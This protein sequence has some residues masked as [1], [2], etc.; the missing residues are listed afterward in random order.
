META[1]NDCKVN[2]S[3][4]CSFQLTFY[5]HDNSIGYK[6]ETIGRSSFHREWTSVMV[7]KHP[8]LI[9]SK[10]SCKSAIIQFREWRARVESTQTS[11]RS[12]DIPQEY[13]DLVA[14]LAHESDESLNSLANRLNDLLSP[15]E[16]NH[17]ATFSFFKTIKQIIKMSAY[18]ERYG[19]ADV[20]L[21]MNG[22]PSTMPKRLSIFRW[23]AYDTTQFPPDVV[24]AATKKREKRKLF[25]TIFTNAFQS[26]S[27]R[28]RIDLLYDQ[29]GSFIIES[30]L[31]E[32]MNTKTALFSSFKQQ[33]Y[34]SLAPIM[35]Q[36]RKRLCPSFD[37]L[38]YVGLN[39][40][41]DLR[42]RFLKELPLETKL[43]RGILMQEVDLKKA[44]IDSIK[45]GAVTLKIKG[46]KMKLLQFHEDVRPAYFGTWTKGTGSQRTEVTGRRPFAKDSTLDYEYD[47]EAE[48]DHDVDGDDIYTLDPDEDEA[49][50]LPTDEEEEFSTNF[51]ITNG[52]EDESKWV[53]PEGYL[54]E[55]EGIHVGKLQKH[56]RRVVSRPA[57]WPIAGNK[58]FPMKPV[59]VGPSFETAE[60]PRNHP[61]LDLKIHMLV[62]VTNYYDNEGYSPF[63]T[64]IA[65]KN[66]SS[67][68]FFGQNK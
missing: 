1:V 42:Q 49:V 30:S 9:S 33:D 15:F 21:L 10:Y 39:D 41:F 12:S 5:I 60:E 58:H 61:L 4:K 36:S 14:M 44:W 17:E 66:P 3:F 63:S 47:S 26:L 65:S 19:L 25:S 38:F 27:E 52:D 55:D 43:K 32:A 16:K 56:K 8:I 57:K 54:S 64:N 50:M 2:D 62:N 29:N 13:V 51:S 18:Q 11:I 23:Q 34:V 20:V 46:L 48:W 31:D 59:I 28:E 53:V 22:S 40:T 35:Q 7:I 67:T 68:S 6:T 37:T 24:N 45:T